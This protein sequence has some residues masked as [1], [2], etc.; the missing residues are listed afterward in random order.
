MTGTLATGDL[1]VVTGADSY[2]VGDIA[3]YRVPEGLGK[4]QIVIHRIKGGDA[5][6]GFVMQGDAN[7][8]PDIWHPTQR[9]M[10][11]EIMFRVPR[12]GTILGYSRNPAI[13]GAI[14]AM[15]AFILVFGFTVAGRR[16]L[17]YAAA[18]G[19]ENWPLTDTQTPH[20][21]VQA[22]YRETE[23]EPG[24]H[25]YQAWSRKDRQ[26]LDVLASDGDGR[27]TWFGGSRLEFGD[28]MLITTDERELKAYMGKR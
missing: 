9:D 1:V 17:S 21:V 6:S 28:P 11:G 22:I 8:N 7:R 24:K 27:E 10:V 26:W 18:Y 19:L 12:F 2:S 23:K 25:V 16:V 4:G 15:V 3:A 14:W 20:W 5:V 13:L